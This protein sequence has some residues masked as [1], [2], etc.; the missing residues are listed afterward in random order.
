MTPYEVLI[1][2]T[3]LLV[4][5]IAVILPIAGFTA[6]FALK[7]AVEAMLKLRSGGSDPRLPLLEQRLALMEE[8]FHALERS[9]DRLRE[10]A[11]FQR[12][13]SGGV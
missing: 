11:E 12:Q 4:G 3:A 10:A 7:P 6:R 2:I 1:P 13:L 8:Q 5:G 9:H